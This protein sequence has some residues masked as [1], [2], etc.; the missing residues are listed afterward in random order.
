MMYAIVLEKSISQK[1]NNI[2]VN[3]Y[4]IFVTK[5]DPAKY[6]SYSSDIAILG[7]D[8][9]QTSAEERAKE[10]AEAKGLHFAGYIE[11]KEEFDSEEQV[12]PE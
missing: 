11:P 5:F 12:V 1:I 4:I 6:L 2:E 8:H 3:K 9:D 10:F 7:I